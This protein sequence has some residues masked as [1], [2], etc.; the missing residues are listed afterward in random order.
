MRRCRERRVNSSCR[1][2]D[3]VPQTRRIRFLL[4][5][6]LS[7]R[8]RPHLLSTVPTVDNDAIGYTVKSRT[9]AAIAALYRL[10]QIRQGNVFLPNTHAGSVSSALLI[11]TDFIPLPLSHRSTPPTE[12]LLKVVKPT[13]SHRRSPIR[14]ILMLVHNLAIQRGVCPVGGSVSISVS[15]LEQPYGGSSMSTCLSFR[16]RSFCRGQSRSARCRLGS[17]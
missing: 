2:R 10:D 14:V 9:T 11:Q 8:H 5:R 4:C 12:G 1:S 6:E 13:L 16:K 3:S 15:N 17:A 7:V